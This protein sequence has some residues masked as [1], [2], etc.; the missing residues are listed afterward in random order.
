MND[1]E[2]NQE[3]ETLKREITQL[4]RQVESLS[5]PAT[6]SEE[7]LKTLVSKGF[8]RYDNVKILTYT[9][10]R[11]KDFYSIFAKYGNENTVLSIEDQQNFV[12]IESINVSTNVITINNHGFS[13]ATPVYIVSTNTF[14]GNLGPQVQYYIRDATTNTF[15]LAS[16][17][18]GTAIDI[19]SV[20]AGNNYIRPQ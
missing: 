18:G 8:I 3:I 2:Q 4:K 5:N 11:G 14:P 12:K 7:F 13:D 16:T 19:T 17:V 20:G 1:S 15:K 10:P 6:I 9:N